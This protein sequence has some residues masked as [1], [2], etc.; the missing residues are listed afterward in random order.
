MLLRIDMRAV[1]RSGMEQT[2]DLDRQPCGWHQ[3]IKR[4]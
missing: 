2:F 1:S 3:V 4:G